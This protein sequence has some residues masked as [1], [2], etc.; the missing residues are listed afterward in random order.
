METIIC[1]KCAGNEFWKTKDKRVKCKNCKYLFKPKDNPLNIPNEKL[2]EIISEFIL[3]NSIQAISNKVQISK[4]KLIKIFTILRELISL[5]FPL[6]IREVL[7]IE[8]NLN[9]TELNPRRR[10]I[11]GVFSYKDWVFAKI[12]PEIKPKEIKIFIENKNFEPTEEWQKNFA[13]IYNKKLYRFGNEN[14]EDTI[15]EFWR[16]LIEKISSKG[17]IRKNKIHLFLGEYVWRFNNRKK[18]LKEKEEKIFHLLNEFFK[19]KKID[20]I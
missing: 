19:N 20:I 12:L 11:I 4:Y 3:E 16:Y 5:D 1:P 7:K 14:Q 8:P 13:L 6:E 9:K 15:N 2:K 10:P 17:G 18:D